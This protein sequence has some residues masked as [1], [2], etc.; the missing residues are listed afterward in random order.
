MAGQKKTSRLSD[1]LE[2][3]GGE[4]LVFPLLA[5]GNTL[6]AV[7]RILSREYPD[8]LADLSRGILSTWCNRPQR[9]EAYVEARRM[10]AVVFAE[11]SVEIVDRA[12]PETAY[13]SKLKSDNRR[14]M[15]G[16]LDHEAWGDRTQASTQINIGQMHLEAVKQLG[17]AAEGEA[18]P[19][20]IEGEIVENPAAGAGGE[21]DWLE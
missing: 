5:E 21:D 11:D 6:A 19:E 15:A 14:W 3:C 18:G 20:L 8:E 16:K 17:R 2:C 9:K 10:G 13:L 7:V 1:A 4:D 12:T